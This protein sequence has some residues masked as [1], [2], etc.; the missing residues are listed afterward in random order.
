[1]FLLSDNN[2]SISSRT[3]S[4]EAGSFTDDAFGQDPDQK[5]INEA[6]TVSLIKIF[7]FCGLHINEQNKYS[8]CPFKS[9]KGGRENSASF[10][11]YVETNSFYCFGCNAGGKHAHACEFLAAYDQTSKLASAYKIIKLFENDVDPQAALNVEQNN[12]SER[13]DI[14]MDFSNAIREFRQTYTSEDA[15]NYAEQTC[16]QYDSTYLKLDMDNEALFRMVELLKE[17]LSNYSE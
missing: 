2:R 3:P 9:H 14:M 5:L 7:R 12:F 13:L 17:Y 11:Y 15:W 1:M 16:A 6:N 4:G 10:Q 8:I